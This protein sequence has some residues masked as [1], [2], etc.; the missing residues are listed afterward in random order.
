VIEGPVISIIPDEA[1]AGPVPPDFSRTANQLQ[2]YNEGVKVGEVQSGEQM[3]R[4]L[5]RF[6]D[7]TEN[8]LES[9]RRQPVF[10]PM[11]LSGPSII[12]ARVEL[13]KGTPD[14]TREDL[15]SN[16]VVTARLER[17]DLGSAVREIQSALGKSCSCPGVLHRIRRDIRRTT[18]IFSHPDDDPD[19]CGSSWYLPFFF[20]FSVTCGFHPGHLYFSP[21]YRRVHMGAL[22]HG[23]PTERRQLYGHHHDRRDHCRERNLHREPVHDY[24]ENKRGR[25]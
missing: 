17:R 14:V 19:R 3:L 21:R 13:S 12:F 4:I 8:Y 24:H 20:S 1:K 25:R 18:G 2:A 15:K 6:T 10:S 16:I 23:H 7:F 5:L 11:A 22:C 9:I